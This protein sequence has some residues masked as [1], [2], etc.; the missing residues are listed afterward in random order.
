MLEVDLLWQKINWCTTWESWLSCQMSTGLENGLINTRGIRACSLY[1]H[2]LSPLVLCCLFTADWKA[3]LH[4]S[5]QP[6]HWSPHV[7]VRCHLQENFR[8]L[9]CPSPPFAGNSFNML[10]TERKL[11]IIPTQSSGDKI[12]ESRTLDPD[13]ASTS[14]ICHSSVQA[15]IN[16]AT[17]TSTI[18]LILVFKYLSPTVKSKR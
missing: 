17:T 1:C 3:P 12:L 14:P 5:R 9:H 10:S 11:L 4:L 15:G 18:Q 8:G 16:W 13:F 7:K 6:A 2:I